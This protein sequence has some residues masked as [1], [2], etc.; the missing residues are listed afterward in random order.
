LMSSEDA[1][2]MR[3]TIISLNVRMCTAIRRV[4]FACNQSAL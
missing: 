3:A 4:S 1:P 2:E